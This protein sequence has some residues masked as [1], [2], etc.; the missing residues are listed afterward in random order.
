MMYAMI[1]MFWCDPSPM[2]W[3][4]VTLMLKVSLLVNGWSTQE[5][6]ALP[7]EPDPEPDPEPLE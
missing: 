6:V 7:P 3:L 2:V 4:Y 1:S 5:M